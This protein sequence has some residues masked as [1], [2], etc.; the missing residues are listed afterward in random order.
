MDSGV[1]VLGR[2]EPEKLAKSVAP[3]LLFKLFMSDNNF[4]ASSKGLVKPCANMSV[5]LLPNTVTN[6]DPSKSNAVIVSVK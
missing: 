5:I 3:E 6:R 1:I 2:E 4:L